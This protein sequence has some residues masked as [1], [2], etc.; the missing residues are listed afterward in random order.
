MRG[1]FGEVK[2]LIGAGSDAA[3]DSQAA[4]HNGKGAF[5]GA[6]SDRQPPT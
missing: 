6:Q 2:A 3:A 5:R 1:S 4:L